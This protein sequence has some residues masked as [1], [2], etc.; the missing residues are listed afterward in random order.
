MANRVFT[1]KQNHRR[2]HRLGRAAT[3]HRGNVRSART[4]NTGVSWLQRRKRPRH[5]FCFLF[6]FFFSRSHSKTQLAKPVPRT[7]VI[8]LPGQ[9]GPLVLVLAFLSH[10]LSAS[11]LFPRGKCLETTTGVFARL[12]FGEL[13]KLL[14]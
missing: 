9:G 14:V 1:S 7:Q 8:T 12:D 3:D 5:Q 13:T 11:P 10:R 2:W 6:L 4:L